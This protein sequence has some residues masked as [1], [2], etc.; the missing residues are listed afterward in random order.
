MKESKPNLVSF[1]D[2]SCGGII[3]TLLN[4]NK[5]NF[6][7]LRFSGSI[8]SIE[9]DLLKFTVDWGK[10]TQECLPG[11][12]YSTHRTIEEIDCSY[13]N[14]IIN[15]TTEHKDSQLVIFKR[16][17]KYLYPNFIHSD[18]LEQIDKI[19]ELC[20]EYV[21]KRIRNKNSKVTNLELADFLNEKTSLLDYSLDQW[22]TW[23]EENS[24]IFKNDNWISNR[25][26]EAQWEIKNK[27]PFKYH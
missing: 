16:V 21:F 26:G 27:K 7:S 18:S 22:K 8:I 25:F 23:K 5:I 4:N 6:N 20:K 11:F 2:F 3:I 9:H 13:F 15:I 14:K 19:R 24:Y 10:D 17:I 12:W 1:T